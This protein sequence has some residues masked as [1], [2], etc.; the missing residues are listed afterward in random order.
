[1]RAYYLFGQLL[2]PF[3]TMAFFLY[4]K[5]TH[6]PRARVIILNEQGEVLL[7]RNWARERRWG[8]PGGGIQRKERP[9]QAAKR[10]LHEELGVVVPIKNLQLI[11][12]L[13]NYSYPA[14]IYQATIKKRQLPAEPHN[15]WEIT[16]MEWFALHSLPKLSPMTREALGLLADKS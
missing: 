10:E 14:L 1:M 6:R 5:I 4:N 13:Q 16:H 15:P 3:A 9:V 2:R 8:L 12:T 7:V 11:A